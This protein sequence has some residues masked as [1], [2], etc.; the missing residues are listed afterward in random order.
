MIHDV[1]LGHPVTYLVAF[2]LP[3]VDGVIP[4]VPAQALVIAFGVVAGTGDIRAVPLLGLAALGAFFSDNIAYLLGAR[5]GQR[6]ADRLLRGKQ[7]RKTRAW[8]EHALRAHGTGLITASRVVPGGPTPITLMAGL[9]HVA[10]RRF[11]IAAAAAALL[12][13]AYGCATGALGETAALGHPLVGL[14]A[15]L[16]LAAAINA[17]IVYLARHR[18]SPP[19]EPG[20]ASRDAGVP[21]KR[22]SSS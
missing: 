22:C 6:I 7:A 21:P 18:G 11:R 16:L 19:A 13:V 5:Y 1:D 4:L 2:G 9:A 12:W 3:L 8:A 20:G 17:V 14:A 15:G 10:P